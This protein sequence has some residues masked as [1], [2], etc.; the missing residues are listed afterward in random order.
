[1]DDS[2]PKLYEETRRYI[3]HITNRFRDVF[4]KDHDRFI[5]LFEVIRNEYP[6]QQF[7]I[8]KDPNYNNI[9]AH[10]VHKT[11]FFHAYTRQIGPLYVQ[12]GIFYICCNGKMTLGPVE[13][14]IWVDRLGDIEFRSIIRGL[15]IKDYDTVSNP[16]EQRERQKEMKDQAEKLA[17]QVS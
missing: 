11:L 12:E 13:H 4:L 3:T 9:K 5:N 1:M 15:L 6:H 10:T 2:F 14:Q 16:R 7:M 17:M 8:T